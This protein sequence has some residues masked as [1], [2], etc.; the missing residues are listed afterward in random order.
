MLFSGE[1]SHTQVTDWVSRVTGV[2]LGQPLGYEHRQSITA[3]FASCPLDPP[4]PAGFAHTGSN[5]FCRY[6]PTVGGFAG[7]ANAELLSCIA[8]NGN[9][10]QYPDMTPTSAPA[11]TARS[12]QYSHTGSSLC[13]R[14]SD[15]G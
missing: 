5:R 1:H 3:D 12:G 13:V 7:I 8:N 9:G 2:G 10:Y 14:K 15:A 4:R 11:S 6:I